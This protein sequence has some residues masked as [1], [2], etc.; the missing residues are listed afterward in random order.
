ME[1]FKALWAKLMLEKNHIRLQSQLKHWKFYL[2][3]QL[4]VIEY[5]RKK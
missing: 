3:L 5:K 2:Q 4:I 1:T